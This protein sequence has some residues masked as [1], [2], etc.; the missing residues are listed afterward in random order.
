MMPGLKGADTLTLVNNLI[1]I[2]L[3]NTLGKILL[4]INAVFLL[5]PLMF[6]LI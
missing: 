4:V 1:L 5:H 2:Q 3:N 6:F